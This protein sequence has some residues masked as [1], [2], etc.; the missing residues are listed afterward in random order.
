M[1][2]ARNIQLSDLLNSSFG[3]SSHS[4]T[5][6]DYD[7]LTGLWTIDELAGNLVAGLVINVDSNRS[8]VLGKYGLFGIV[9]SRMTVM[10]RTIYLR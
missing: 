10:L 6:G 2:M 5:L 4:T 7:P 3:Y 9:I 8:R 1:E